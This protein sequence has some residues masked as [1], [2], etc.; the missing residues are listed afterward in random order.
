VNI[1]IEI[2]GVLLAAIL[3]AILGLQGWMLIALVSLKESVA[4]IKQQIDDK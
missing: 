1:P 4:K 2:V 3:S